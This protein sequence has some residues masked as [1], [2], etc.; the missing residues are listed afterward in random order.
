ALSYT[1]TLPTYS[2]GDVAIITAFKDQDLGDWSIASDGWELG[3]TNR[4][5][6]GRDRSTAVFYKILGAGEANPSIDY[7]DA[8]NDEISWTCHVFR[9]TV[10]LTN[11][12]ILASLA[13]AS[14]QNVQNPDFPV[15][16]I[17]DGG[18]MAFCVQMQTHDDCTAVGAPSGFTIGE[19]IWG[20]VKDN[21]QQLVFYNLDMPSGTTSIGG[22]TSTW[23]ATASEYSVY[24]II[25]G[26]PPLI[27]IDD[28][29]IELYDG[30]ANKVATGFGFGSSQGSGKLE[31]GDN[32]SYASATLVVQNI[33]NWSDASIQFDINQGAISDGLVYIFITNDNGD[34][35][36][37]GAT[38]GEV[39]YT[40]Y[41]SGLTPDHWWRFN[42][43]FVDEV[44]GKDANNQSYDPTPTFSSTELVKGTTQSMLMTDPGSNTEP[45]DSTLMN[46]AQHQRRCIVGW[47]R[48]EKVQLVPSAIFEEG[49]GVNNHYFA[50]GFGNTLLVNV[51]N[52]NTGNYFKI[53]VISDFK[54][55]ANRTYMVSHR[56]EGNG[57]GNYCG[58]DIDG[59]PQSKVAGGEPDNDVMASHSGDISF[60]KPDANLDTGGTDISYKGAVPCHRGEWASWAGNESGGGMIDSITT[61]ELR[62]M[63]LLGMV[64]DVDIV[65]DTTTNMQ[66]DF[67]SYANSAI[68]DAA[69]CM[70]V[71]VPSDATDLTVTATNMIFDQGASKQIQWT[72]SGV[73]TI[74][75]EG[76]SNVLA[77]ECHATI[78][79]NI[80]IEIPATFTVDTVLSGS[81]VEIYD[82]EVSNLENHDT[83]LAYTNSSG[84]S[85]Q[86]SHS[87]TTND[88]VV[89]V[90]KTGYNEQVIPYTLGTTDQ[91]LYASQQIDTN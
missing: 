83:K 87:G 67:A 27:K 58:L 19:T 42:G 24:T 36:S 9:S 74:V 7:S 62:R 3:S 38:I 64:A 86:Y 54:L 80:V 65:T 53:Q 90:F 56:F 61:P 30:N 35:A 22:G 8:T 34:I 12:Y 25:L 75:N 15:V 32:S 81:R 1:V 66:A 89:K 49:G 72:G 79:G 76:S 84:T 4:A 18:G 2:S 5:S 60:G 55:K 26:I 21:R 37:W 39:S 29:P 14:N 16:N 44:G 40:E 77:S 68:A 59:V 82:N 45:G 78:G 20:S 88:I 33:D 31:L 73:L 43:D 46:T 28:A 13:F 70:R 71:N 69:L 41:I 91:V 63:F 11:E 10:A 85:F 50:V 48:L 47:F 6:S 51:A 57:F 17:A 52:S 23:N